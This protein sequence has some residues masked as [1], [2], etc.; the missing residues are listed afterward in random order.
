MNVNAGAN[1]IV[2]IG[3]VEKKGE[4]PQE[5]FL[6][7]Y[8]AAKADLPKDAVIQNYY[9]RRSTWLVNR[10]LQTSYDPAKYV[11]KYQDQIIEL[12]K[13][14]DSSQQQEVINMIR[15]ATQITIKL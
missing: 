9:A 14:V 8:Y 6:G 2:K 3:G 15:A 1:G 4:N 7:D 10:L 11:M 5:E 12:L 13:R